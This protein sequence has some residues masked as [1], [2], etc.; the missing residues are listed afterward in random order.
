MS[1]ARTSTPTNSLVAVN[2]ALHSSST[3]T[4]WS[5]RNQHQALL[6]LLR[7]YATCTFRIKLEVLRHLK[8]HSEMEASCHFKTPRMTLRSWKRIDQVAV[9]KKWKLK[10]K[11][12]HTRK[13][14][15]RPL[16]YAQKFE[17]EL[18]QCILEG[19]DLQIPIQRKSIQRKALVLIQPSK[20]SFRASDGWLQKPMQRHTL[21]LR[22][23][24]FIQQK[25]PANMEKKLGEFL[26]G[27]EGLREHRSPF[28]WQHDNQHGWNS[29]LIWY[30]IGI[31]DKKLGFWFWWIFRAKTVCTYITTPVTPTAV[32]IYVPV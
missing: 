18:V 28:P 25:L 6:G 9:S 4:R 26:D 7:T 21:S 15:G 19:R 27:A 2:E 8:S 11:G 3:T 24:T 16:S 10:L 13:G 29:D 32:R 12:R 20:P 5:E 1:D 23:T 31:K 30:E 17:D 14:A 22:R